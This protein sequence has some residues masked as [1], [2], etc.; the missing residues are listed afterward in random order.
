MQKYDEAVTLLKQ[1]KHQNDQL[2]KSI[3]LEHSSSLTIKLRS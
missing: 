3:G 2:N 1:Y